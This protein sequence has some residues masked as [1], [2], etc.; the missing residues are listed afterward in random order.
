MTSPLR[1]ARS[2]ET[3]IPVH[4]TEPSGAR[5]WDRRHVL[6]LDDFSVSEIEQ[7]LETA[8]AMKEV[9]ARDVPRAPALRGTTIV[10]LFYEASTRT[11]ASFELAGK[12]LGADVINLTASGSSVEKGE[13]L[14]DTVRTLR[15]IGAHVLIMRHPMSGAPYLAASHGDARVVNAG[16]GWHAHPTQGLLDLY[17]LRNHIGS[18]AGKRV[19][20]VGD[21]TH[22]RVA[23][24][25]IWGLSKLG[26]EVVVCGPPTLLPAELGRDHE[27]G[28]PL[29]TV[30]TDFDKAVQGADAVMTLRLQQER[31]TGGLLPSL[32]EYSRL[33]QVNEARMEKARPGAPVLHP[34]PIN[35]GVEISAAVA[36]G[37]RSLIEEQVTNGVAVRMALLYLMRGLK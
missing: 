21:V 9:L 37:A 7:V 32:R 28:L 29:V 4:L 31:M 6:D 11:R 14:I 18:L 20:I 3:A 13:S 15:A 10:T 19:V 16:D 17:T 36:H 30:E 35:E 24:S 8:D 26:A 12:V 27:D 5:E 33:Y 34:G 1:E 22:S 25:D 2:R 23:R